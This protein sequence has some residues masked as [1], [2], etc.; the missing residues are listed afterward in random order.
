[1]EVQAEKKLFLSK[2]KEKRWIADDNMNY[3]NYVTRLFGDISLRLRLSQL[4]LGFCRRKR[5]ARCDTRDARGERDTFGR[6]S[7]IR[8]RTQ[9][10]NPQRD[11][12]VP[13]WFAIKHDTIHATRLRG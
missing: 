7:N 2:A 6:Q 3:G 12:E 13:I 9:T 11:S 5:T 4:F 1:M 8:Y 10:L